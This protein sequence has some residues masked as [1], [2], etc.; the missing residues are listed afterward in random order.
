M[1]RG[2][3]TLAGQSTEW[4]LTEILQ[5]LQVERQELYHL[6]LRLRASQTCQHLPFLPRQPQ[7]HLT[8]YLWL[9]MYGF[10][11]VVVKQ[12]PLRTHLRRL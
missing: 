5:F 12:F 10:L 3:R 1:S 6:R 11:A 8:M 4:N 9:L 2:Q 7:K